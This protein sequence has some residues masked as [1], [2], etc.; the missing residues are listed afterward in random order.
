MDYVCCFELYFPIDRLKLSLQS[1]YARRNQLFAK[2]NRQ[3]GSLETTQLNSVNS[4]SRLHVLLLFIQFL[5]HSFQNLLVLPIKLTKK[6]SS[7]ASLIYPIKSNF[8]S[9]PGYW[10]LVWTWGLIVHCLQEFHFLVNKPNLMD[11]C[12]DSMMIANA[13]SYKTRKYWISP[14]L[15]LKQKC[16]KCAV[17]QCLLCYLSNISTSKTYKV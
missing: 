2:T 17:P 15:K 5:L 8:L 11:I 14:S 6:A 1:G 4:S 9:F 7:D 3:T 12:I 13:S 16:L 10:F